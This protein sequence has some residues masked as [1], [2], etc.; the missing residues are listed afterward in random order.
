MEELKL[1]LE[2]ALDYFILNTPIKELL[3]HLEWYKAVNLYDL[4][5]VMYES[6]LDNYDENELK[7]RIEDL[8]K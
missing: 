5:A 6:Y 2:K 4:K 7:E 8:Y 1:E 3:Q